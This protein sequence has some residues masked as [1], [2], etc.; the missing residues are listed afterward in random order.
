MED[1]DK[2]WENTKV[3]VFDQVIGR[4]RTERTKEFDRKVKRT[5]ERKS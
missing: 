4:S 5:S 3:R 2:E 1:V